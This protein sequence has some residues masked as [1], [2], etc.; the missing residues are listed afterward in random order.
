MDP[1]DGCTER[2][3]KKRVNESFEMFDR[4]CSVLSVIMFLDYASLSHRNRKRNQS[5]LIWITDHF[6]AIWLSVSVL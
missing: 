3:G 6:L 1:T 5:N 2:K 4:L